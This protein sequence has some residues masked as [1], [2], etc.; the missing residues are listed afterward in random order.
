MSVEQTTPSCSS[1]SDEKN[2]VF[3]TYVFVFTTLIT[4]W[5][6]A[7]RYYPF[8]INWAHPLVV[9]FVLGWLAWYMTGTD[10][11]SIYT[12]VT[13]MAKTAKDRNDAMVGLLSGV[14]T[15]IIIVF[16]LANSKNIV[17]ALFPGSTRGNSVAQMLDEY[18]WIGGI[19]P[20]YLG[21]SV[22][23][24]YWKDDDSED[25][26]TQLLKKFGKST[27]RVIAF[28]GF[29]MNSS[30]DHGYN[31]AM[32]VGMAI[33]W[34]ITF[35]SAVFM[36][37]CSMHVIVTHPKLEKYK[38]LDHPLLRGSALFVV[39][40]WITIVHF[41]KHPFLIPILWTCCIL[42]AMFGDTVKDW[43]S[44]QLNKNQSLKNSDE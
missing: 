40:I 32:T 30:D 13:R 8:L 43:V 41:K 14:A 34:Q 11:I 42:W 35:L 2:D 29:I 22:L 9:A 33:L 17:S 21:T 5:G 16:I 23:W 10:D 1:H 39:G 36:A 6:V 28:M 27:L 7:G 20:I 31:F 15:M 44:Q 3:G 37:A 18:T 38:F 25:A 4:I 26:A 12:S 24:C 19:L